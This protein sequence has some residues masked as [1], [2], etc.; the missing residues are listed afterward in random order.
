MRLACRVR[1]DALAQRG[2]QRVEVGSVRGRRS[3]HEA[4]GGGTVD[5]VQHWLIAQ[6]GEVLGYEVHDVPAEPAHRFVVEVERG[7]R[8]TCG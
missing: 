4:L 5:D 3:R 7:A 2:E 6:R 8:V 1:E